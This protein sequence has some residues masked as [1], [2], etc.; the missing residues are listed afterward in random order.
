MDFVRLEESFQNGL[1]LDAYMSYKGIYNNAMAKGSSDLIPTSLMG[2][3]IQLDSENMN[4]LFNVDIER[5]KIHYADYLVSVKLDG[6]RFLMLIGDKTPLGTRNIYFVDSKLHFWHCKHFHPIP[7]KS[8][9]DKTIMDG[10][11]LFWGDVDVEWD[12]DGEI[13]S[14]RVKGPNRHIAFVAFDMLYGPTNPGYQRQDAKEGVDMGNVG[15]IKQKHEYFKRYYSNSD[16]GIFKYALGS[17]GAMVGLKSQTLDGR[18][19]TRWPTNRRRFSLEMFF[20]HQDSPFWKYL[21]VVEGGM[22][23]KMLEKKKIDHNTREE[24][25]ELAYDV[26]NHERVNIFISPFFPMNDVL[27][28]DPHQMYETLKK[29]CDQQL[30]SQ[31]FYT[32]ESKKEPRHEMAM[33]EG[34]DEVKLAKRVNTHGFEKPG[35]ERGVLRFP[36]GLELPPSPKKVPNPTRYTFVGSGINF[37]GLI[38]TPMRE[39][40]LIGTWS[41]CGNKQYKWKPIEALTVDLKIGRDYPMTVKEHHG[42]DTLERTIHKYVAYVKDQ[43]ELEQLLY[44]SKPVFI[45]S[46]QELD[47]NHIAECRLVG[48]QANDFECQFIKYRPDK[49]DP[50]AQETAKSVFRA[51]NV[52]TMKDFKYDTL[53]YL[54]VK[55]VKTLREHHSMIVKID[56]KLSNGFYS[57]EH[58]HE[59]D[60]VVTSPDKELKGGEVCQILFDHAFK[61]D[62]HKNKYTIVM[63]LLNIEGNEQ[64]Y[65]DLNIL[66]K[67]TEEYY[68]SIF[69]PTVYVA[70]NGIF[71]ECKDEELVVGQKVQ[72][73]YVQMLNDKGDVWVKFKKKTNRVDPESL[74]QQKLSEITHYVD[75]NKKTQP[76]NMLDVVMTIK[77]RLPLNIEEFNKKLLSFLGTTKIQKAFTSFHPTAFFDE[78]T[79]KKICTMLDQVK[80]NSS[81]EFE[82]QIKMQNPRLAYANCLLTN[83]VGTDYLPQPLV[84]GYTMSK[85]RVNYIVLGDNI[86]P[87]EAQLKQSVES[88]TF[89]NELFN[90]SVDIQLSQE[91]TIDMPS[92]RIKQY[93]Y[94]NR[95]VLT[96]VSRFWRVDIIE[97]GA[98]P[99]SWEEARAKYENFPTTRIEIEYD[100]G[101]Y[102]T[103]LIE[104]VKKDTSTNVKDV[105]GLD[106]KSDDKKLNAYRQQ[107][108]SAD[109]LDIYKDLCDIIVRIVETLDMSFGN[110]YNK[111]KQQEKQQPKENESLW[112]RMR[113]F[114]NDIKR[115]QLLSIVDKLVSQVDVKTYTLFDVSVGRGGDTAKWGELP[116]IT[117][118]IGIDPGEEYILEA[119]RRFKNGNFSKRDFKYFVGSIGSPTDQPVITSNYGQCHIVSCQFSLHYLFES[120]DMLKTMVQN[121]SKLLVPGGF[122]IGTTIIGDRVVNMGDV[123]V[124]EYKIE[125]ID[126]RSYKFK[127]NDTDTSGNYFKTK[128]AMDD[129]TTEYL[130]EFKEFLNVC[131]ENGLKFIEKK[132][133]KSIY[134]SRPDI[135]LRPYEIDITSLYDTFVFQKYKLNER[136]TFTVDL[137]DFEASDDEDDLEE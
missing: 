133:F 16:F 33:F 4:S 78:D 52:K 76:P 77:N 106:L 62:P 129:A 81:L 57:I 29:E 115:R 47:I 130:V 61:T 69:G 104:R 45:Y 117:R 93:Q 112:K 18:R 32:L 5:N 38:L 135:Q 109:T 34:N 28:E 42:T 114:H 25:I 60:V 46:D 118:A 108:R 128:T 21:H 30:R 12:R 1:Y 58:C 51:C 124:P 102:Y 41:F 75:Y 98:S 132:S 73:V 120:T 48:P 86:L 134:D 82:C 55:E 80:T 111:K 92:E 11:I 54:R 39:P 88:C 23:P 90:Y 13:R 26:A 35:R 44:E 68:E 49:R 43:G 10:E 84:R 14:Y 2:N 87:F 116:Q 103:H 66:E 64:T 131:Q 122:F 19:I 110:V 137:N 65:E 20:H 99:V 56:R 40:Y 67:A 36:D 3:P 74:T 70:D 85:K 105:F 95:Y 101:S 50:N 96:H 136:E 59:H 97:F 107:L 100:P 79:M 27:K 53:L 94:Q 6:L 63:K 71:I 91:K 121:V 7:P 9:I 123:E 72:A 17:H 126:E 8:N 83:L 22:I 127:L 119:N 31:M 24:Y 89:L 37:D 15:A 113:D 125:F